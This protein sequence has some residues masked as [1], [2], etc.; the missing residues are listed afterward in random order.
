MAFAALLAT[1]AVVAVVLTVAHRGDTAGSRELGVFAV[2]VDNLLRQSTDG[3]TSIASTIDG[4]LTCR[5][6]P[7][8]AARQ[9][10]A[11]ER[12][13]QSL[14]QQI[15]ALQV[16]EDRQAIQLSA[17]FQ[18]ALAASID[19]DWRYRDWLAGLKACPRGTPPPAGV[20]A[21]NARSTKLK[22]A[23]VRAW[24]PLAVRYGLP[25]R[26]PQEL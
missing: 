14:L 11:A 10:T 16:P 15:A 13:R 6:Q 25:A 12:N 7:R 8:A 17:L 5:L 19:A 22:T 3:R 9:I 26:T 20:T 1:A 2:K 4:A 24:Y 21:A 23:F 18:R